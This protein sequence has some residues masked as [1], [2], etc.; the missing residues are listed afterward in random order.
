M[1]IYIMGGSQEGST[2]RRGSDLA[3][4]NGER[5]VVLGSYRSLAAPRKGPPEP[6]A[7]RDH[8]VVVL[9]DGTEV[10]L[11]PLHSPKAERPPE[12]RQQLEGKNVRV[13]GTAHKIMPSRGE[14]LIS[15]C[16]DDITR[17]VEDE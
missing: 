1:G 11:E 5:V 4:H 13:S 16:I 9:A 15:P 12:E 14:S 3:E 17:I 6:N 7:S 10:F 2:V 8:A